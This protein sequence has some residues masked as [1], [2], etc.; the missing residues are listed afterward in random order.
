[1]NRLCFS[2]N[3]SEFVDSSELN[4]QG[5]NRFDVAGATGKQRQFLNNQ[6]KAKLGLKFH[7]VCLFLVISFLS[8]SQEYCRIPVGLRQK[9]QDALDSS[10]NSL[11]ITGISAAISL[12]DNKVLTIVS[13]YSYDGVEITPKTL[14]GAGSITKNFI[15]A[16]ILQLSEERK[17]SLNDPISKYFPDHNN[18]DGNATIKE[19]LNHT[20]GIFDYT[21]NE[22]FFDFVFGDPSKIWT[23]EELFT[24]VLEPNFEHGTNWRYSN[25]DYIILGCIIQKITGHKISDLLNKRFFRPLQLKSTVLYPDQELKGELSNVYLDGMDFTDFVGTSL[26]SCAWTAGGIV[27]TPT[28]LVKWSKALYGGRV[29]KPS[30][31]GKM[32]EPSEFNP[33][34]ALGTMLLDVDGQMTY[35]HFGDILYN[36]YVNYF[37]KDKL[38]IA[39]MGNKANTLVESVMLALYSAY[40]NYNQQPEYPRMEITCYPNPFKN[41]ITFSYELINDA[42]VTLKISNM[43]GRQISILKN[44]NEQSGEHTI[45]WNGTDMKGRLVSPGMYYYTFIVDKQIY[46]GVIIK[47]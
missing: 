2:R 21:E 24:Y 29:L 1:M 34:Y 27:S 7:W 16:T 13:G 14:F 19:L 35:G 33:N 36:S 31:I 45:T 4:E 23:T 37:P 46:G 17:I 43:F 5:Q 10:A 12:P 26:F 30:S 20:G 41:S 38:S 47:Q 28:D 6:Y 22:V 15:A 42:H 3:G 9:L 18:I 11:D 39:V 40:K 25:T 44:C 8:Y 32:L